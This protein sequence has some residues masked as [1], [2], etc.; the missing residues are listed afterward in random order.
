MKRFLDYYVI[1]SGYSPTELGFVVGLA[2]VV[3]LLSNLYIAPFFLRRMHNFRFLQIQFI[4]APILL[5]LTFSSEDLM[6]GLYTFYMGY[7]IMLAVYEP[8][9]ISF[10]SDNKAISQGV[11]VGVRQSVVGLGMTLGFVIGGIL[12]G[13]EEMYVFYLAVVFYV[14]VFLGFS[15]LIMLQ[16]KVVKDYRAKYLKE[17]HK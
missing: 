11:L 1:D 8:T 2:G 3:G 4:F 17:A 10:M 7:T 9:A 15:I 12:Y 16:Y 13:Y 5:L 6:F 14:I